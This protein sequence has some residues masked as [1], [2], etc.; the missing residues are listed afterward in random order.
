M[1]VSLA[2]VI[3]EVEAVIGDA[4]KAI[5]AL[6]ALV[7]VA[8]EVVPLLPEA[9]QAFVTDGETIVNALIDVLSKV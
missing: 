3:A 6:Q 5:P 7:K 1:S 2:N 9:D 4:D 8:A